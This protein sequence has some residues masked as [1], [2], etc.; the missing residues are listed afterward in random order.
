MADATPTTP[1]PTV[2][3]SSPPHEADVLVPP[4]A[5][6]DGASE[7][8]VSDADVPVHSHA[9]PRD[10]AERAQDRLWWAAAVVWNRRWWIAALAILTGVVAV[11]V[12]LQIPNRYRAENRL[13]LPDTGGSL[14]ALLGR[15]SS[16]AAAL[17]GGGGG[18]YTR[19]LAILTA[20]STMEEIVE[21]FD[22]VQVYK[23]EDEEDPLGE[24]IRKLA[25]RA[26]FEVSLDFDYLAVQVLDEDPERAAR[27]ANAFVEVLNDEHI[28]LSQESAATYRVYL[29]RRLDR[30]E[31]DLDS[32]LGA[33]QALQER[34]GI[35]EPEAQGAAFMESLASA[36]ALVASA[37]VEYEMLRSELGDE[38]PQTRT[39]AAGLAAARR[40]RD[41]LTTGSE[42]VMPVPI[43]G[44]PMVGRQYAEVQQSLLIQGEILKAL[45]PLYEQS[46]LNEQRRADAVQVL[47]R[48]VPPVRKAEPRRSLLVVASVLSVVVLA[49]LLLIGGA[50]LH[51]WAPLAAA[52]LDAAG[53]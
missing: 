8:F 38:N 47:D 1:V 26:D 42:A 49:V 52:R 32:L 43:S 14:T 4:D 2:S 3:P 40:Q 46:L 48:A 44:L 11:F 35:V 17:L 37:E 5:T 16:A 9:P 45:Q 7:A 34:Y 13:L 23:T 18:S 31:T 28:E 50:A 12:T 6:G 25:D 19:Y 41:R 10:P 51:R 20:R 27:M 22:L 30:A 21:R 24:A 39:A 33:Q 36:Q 15:S 53:A 29:E